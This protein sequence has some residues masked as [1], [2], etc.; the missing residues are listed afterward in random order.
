MSSSN[1]K[2]ELAVGFEP[3][4]YPLQRGCSTTELHQ[5]YTNSKLPHILSIIQG[6]SPANARWVAYP[7]PQWFRDAASQKSSVEEKLLVYFYCFLVGQQLLYIRK[8][9]VCQAN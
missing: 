4:T 8:R 2:K 3:T 1:L 9:L 5:Q 6:I 7:K